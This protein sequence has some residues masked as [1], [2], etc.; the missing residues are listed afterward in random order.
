MLARRPVSEPPPP[1]SSDAE[2][3]SLPAAS[4]LSGL[5]ARLSQGDRRLLVVTAPVAALEAIAAHV[6]RRFILAGSRVVRTTSGRGGEGFRLAIAQLRGRAG[7]T[8]SA[9][10][11]AAELVAR[12]SSPV[13]PQRVV[14]VEPSTSRYARA[15]A[16]E[17]DTCDQSGAGPSVVWVTTPAS[18]AEG[19]LGLSDVVEMSG[20]LASDEVEAWWSAASAS[21][22]PQLR[23][24]DALDEWWRSAQRDQ[25]PRCA[26][27]G[28][29]ADLASALAV[30]GRPWPEDKVTELV[31][32]ADRSVALALASELVSLGAAEVRA[33]GA[34]RTLV[35]VGAAE[36]EP[37]PEVAGR[38]VSALTK[39]FSDDPWALFRAAELCFLVGDGERGDLLAQRAISDV[40]DA[41]ARADFWARLLAARIEKVATAS[42]L[43]GYVSLGLFTGDIE[44]A[45][46]FARDAASLEPESAEV[47]LALG[48]CHA[49]LG[50][51][52]AALVTLQ[53]AAERTAD[54]VVLARIDVEVAEIKYR[55]GNLA[56]AGAAAEAAVARLTRATPASTEVYL[57]ARNVLGK[58]LLARGAFADAE[59]HFAADGCE[60]SLAKLGVAELKARVNRAISVLY[61]GRRAEAQALLETGLEEAERQGEA[62]RTGHALL[63]LAVI[64]T[65]D[66]RYA[67]A[68]EITERAAKGVLRVGDR[69]AF[70][71]CAANLADLRL[72][73]GLV[74]EA[75]Q[76]LRFGARG[77]KG[78]VPGFQAAQ[79][80]ITMAR[81]HLER[82]DTALA[83]QVILRAL[84]EVGANIISSPRVRES[85]EG[86]ARGP[87]REIV[88][89]AFRVAARIALEDGDTVRAR[90]L[91]ENADQE[92][93]GARA[94]ADLAVIRAMLGRSLG[95]PFAEVAHKALEAAREADDIELLREAHVLLHHA[96]MASGDLAAARH[97]LQA[98]ISYRDRVAS[99]LPE[100]L[101][102]SFL[103]RRDIAA[104][105]R[106]MSAFVTFARAAEEAKPV[107]SAALLS[108]S[109]RPTRIVAPSYA[110]GARSLERGIVGEDLAIRAL[111][112]AIGKVGPSDATVLVHGESGTGKELVA[113]ALHE[114]SARRTGPLVKVNCAALVETL[115]LSELFGHEKG[116]FTGAAARRRGRFEAAEGG[117]LFL[118]EIGD[119]SPRTQVALLR[120]L[121]EKTFERVGGTTPIRAN[122][123]VVCATHR[124]LKA[125][126]AKGEFREDLYY[127]LAGVVLEVPALR[128]RLGDLGAIA[129]AILARIA[130]ER[131]GAV[132]KLSSRC[133]AA[134]KTYAWPGNVRELE[135]ALRAASLFADAD[136][137][138]PEDFADN[139]DALRSLGSS[140]D[141]LRAFPAG[142]APT[143]SVAPSSSA[144]AV[145]P[146]PDSFAQGMSFAQPDSVAGRSSI[147][148]PNPSEVA[149]AQVRSGTSL[150]DMKR[151]I[152]RECI[153]RALG[154]AGGN[155][156]RAAALLGMKRPRLSQLVK[157]YGLGSGAAEGDCDDGDEV[158][159]E[160]S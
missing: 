89:Q 64:A 20:Q 117:T 39:V 91:A 37:S 47:L 98:A 4:G 30:V 59:L 45:L 97:H 6:E 93:G 110:A 41:D 149:Y 54:V 44:I 137:L 100:P 1:A 10:D 155:I 109:D 68:L 150:H 3:A 141:T 87:G 130:M 95:E 17:L 86:T 7:E 124:N 33:H 15:V 153:A 121:Q 32:D 94:L 151:I 159:E 65:L 40:V 43:L 99:D 57:E 34:E 49:K 79:F 82:G 113:E 128:S 76:A 71:R 78:P 12:T 23:S 73:L 127:R 53:R 118:D 120:V 135:N 29:A 108:Q 19:P 132:K 61:L 131:G 134:L 154:E 106:E 122:V 66:H 157:Q 147:P 146:P 69:L 35:A 83:Q 25:A 85:E 152:E 67:D 107:I 104:L 18:E 62:V 111:L 13:A 77:F 22:V 60:A 101:R 50:D 55:G 90:V 136:V 2:S 16:A 11:A 42:R 36:G 51:G 102:L 52:P 9:R 56:E 103:A 143:A 114:S 133:L 24:I 31:A 74:A 123:R 105:D 88:N 70:A 116:S 139:V 21:V 81:I 160:E 75:E 72:R 126:V 96:A 63:N 80:S 92:G 58:V 5:E 140:I 14:V 158:S 142:D 156:T 26:P 125:L 38:V 145:P 138:E 129:D 84:S 27:H 112:K 144:F 148:A 119:I 28:R 48:Q 8:L 46:R 115:L